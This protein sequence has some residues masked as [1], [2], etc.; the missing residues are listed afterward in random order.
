MKS[1]SPI[2]RAGAALAALLG[3]IVLLAAGRVTLAG[4]WQAIDASTISL[5][6]GLMVVSAQLRQAGF[7]ARVTRRLAAEIHKLCKVMTVTDVARHFQLDWKTVKDIDK[8]Y[9]EAQYGQPDYN[10]LRILAVDE[11]SIRKGHSYLTV[12]LDYQSGRVVY[13]GRHRKAKT[14]NRFFKQLTAKQRK[15]IEAV[16]MDMWDPYIKAVKKNYPSWR[17]GDKTG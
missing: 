13:I 14:L 7:Y 9:L 15:A 10:G 8:H 4:A 16:V 1:F 11:I 3:A 17:R 2:R 12:V 6:L 5:L